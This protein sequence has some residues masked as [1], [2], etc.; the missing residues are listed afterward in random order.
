MSTQPSTQKVTLAKALN[1]GLRASMEHDDKVLVMGEDFKF[2]GSA[3][4][5]RGAHRNLVAVGEQE[6]VRDGDGIA[7]LG[8]RQGQLQGFTD[9]DLVL[10]ALV[11]D[12]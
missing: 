1:M 3:A 11:F 6:N 7:N 5:F 8:F 2:H 4:D 10:E 12:D 9:G